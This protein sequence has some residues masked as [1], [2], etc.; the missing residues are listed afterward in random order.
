MLNP[1][2]DQDKRLIE[3]GKI[4]AQ[5]AIDLG[6]GAAFQKFLTNVLNKKY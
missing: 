1:N 5:S 4:D 6:P 2:P 3:Q